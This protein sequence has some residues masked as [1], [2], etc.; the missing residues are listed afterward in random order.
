MVNQESVPVSMYKEVPLMASR[1]KLGEA[2]VTQDSFCPAFAISL[3][4][5]SNH[6]FVV[7]K[8]LKE[9]LK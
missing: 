9:L 7:K 6:I 1:A 8:G 3:I 4:L 2:P 5:H